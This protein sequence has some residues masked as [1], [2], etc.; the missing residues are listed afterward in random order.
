MS[1]YSIIQT[2]LNKW[3]VICPMV[4]RAYSTSRLVMP[5]WLPANHTHM[6]IFNTLDEASVRMHNLRETEVL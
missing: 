1:K 5:T 3:A 4:E 6:G 2:P